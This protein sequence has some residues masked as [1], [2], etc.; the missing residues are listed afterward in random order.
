MV[1]DPVFCGRAVAL[2]F[3]T[4]VSSALTLV[5]CPLLYLLWQRKRRH[6]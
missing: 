3:G 1:T 5:V 2:I 4:F 6:A